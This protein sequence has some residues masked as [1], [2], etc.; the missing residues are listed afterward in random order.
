MFAY[1][2][3]SL[4]TLP[5]LLPEAAE[6]RRILA[7]VMDIEPVWQRSD[8]PLG[9]LWRRLFEVLELP[10]ADFARL[11]WRNPRRSRRQPR[12]GERGHTGRCPGKR[13]AGP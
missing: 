10:P 9:T 12:R 8:G 4:Q 6:R 11:P 13:A 7:E 2:E 3:E 5:E 1:P